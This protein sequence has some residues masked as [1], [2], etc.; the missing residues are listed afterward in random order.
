[1][2][3]VDFSGRALGTYLHGIFENHRFTLGVI[4][5]IRRYKGLKPVDVEV[6][7]IAKKRKS[8]TGLQKWSG[9]PLI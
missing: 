8:T 1:L 3:A 9:P 4:N 5:N 7:Y 2:I 6:D